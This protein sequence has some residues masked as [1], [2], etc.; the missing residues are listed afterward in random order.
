VFAP[1]PTPVNTVRAA[2]RCPEA[3]DLA[4]PILRRDLADLTRRLSRLRL[5]GEPYTGV[6]FSGDIVRLARRL[7]SLGS[8]GDDAVH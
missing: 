1:D 2:L 8:M 4:A 5:R 3:V 7:A 6:D